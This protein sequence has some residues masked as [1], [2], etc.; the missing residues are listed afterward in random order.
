M[1]KLDSS[2]KKLYDILKSNHELG[3]N[4]LLD[5]EDAPFSS[6]ST[7]SQHIR[8][9]LDMQLIFQDEAS[10]KYSINPKSQVLTS[11]PSL[12][13]LTTTVNLTISK[14]TLKYETISKLFNQ[15]NDAK[16]LIPMFIENNETTTWESLNPIVKFGKNTIYD[17]RH[18]PQFETQNDNTLKYFLTLDLE[19]QYTELLSYQHTYSNLPYFFTTITFFKRELIFKIQ[20]TDNN[21]PP[22]TILKQIDNKFQ[23]ISPESIKAINPKAYQ[24]K[25]NQIP[26]NTTY[27]IFWDQQEF[28]KFKNKLPTTNFTHQ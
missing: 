16:H 28:Q 9:L 2:C 21:Q 5:L 8:H 10:K 15:S 27:Y 18:P 12:I 7:L 24:F 11:L 4:A 13:T 22:P 25:E 26:A 23:E 1:E 17:K 3:F 14:T 19:P 20:Y 6:T